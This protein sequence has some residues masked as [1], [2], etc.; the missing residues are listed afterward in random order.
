MLTEYVHVLCQRKLCKAEQTYP[1]SLL[2]LVYQFSHLNSCKLHRH[3]DSLFHP[4]SG[5]PSPMIKTLVCCGLGRL[6]ATNC[7]IL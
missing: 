1:A 3:E 2:L 6:L 5:S 7:T 4:V